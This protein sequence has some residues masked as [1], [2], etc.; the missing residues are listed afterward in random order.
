MVL[1]FID[2]HQ[3]HSP[4]KKF[5]QNFTNNLSFEIYV[6]NFKTL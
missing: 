4:Q 2:V 6:Q 5:H 3:Y 1:Y